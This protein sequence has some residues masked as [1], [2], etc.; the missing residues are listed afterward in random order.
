MASCECYSHMALLKCEVV[1]PNDH[2]FDESN[3]GRDPGKCGR[4]V[5]N[6]VPRWWSAKSGPR[7]VM[8]KVGSPPYSPPSKTT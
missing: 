3:I 8:D 1:I 2:I 4:S 5:Y 7:C 6:A